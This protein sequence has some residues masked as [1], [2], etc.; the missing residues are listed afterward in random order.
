MRP[1]LYKVSYTRPVMFGHFRFQR[2]YTA[3]KTTPCA[4]VDVILLLSI[5][6]DTGKSNKIEYH[7]NPRRRERERERKKEGEKERNMLTM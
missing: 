4:K 3:K 2:Q 7:S 1:R 5:S 6:G